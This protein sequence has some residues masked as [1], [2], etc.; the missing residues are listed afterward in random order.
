MCVCLLDIVMVFVCCVRLGLAIRRACG[1][2][3]DDTVVAWEGLVMR[4]LEN[5][6]TKIMLRIAGLWRG[7]CWPPV[8]R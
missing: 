5:K 2:D 7:G 6:R 3:R 4:W 1:C 8:L